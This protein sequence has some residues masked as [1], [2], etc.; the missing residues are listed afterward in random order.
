MRR[1][2]KE[3]KMTQS[4]LAEG[5]I[6]VPYLSLIENERANPPADVIS[7]LA[8]RLK[9]SLHE[10]QGISDPLVLKEAH[11]LIEKIR[12]SMFNEE[13]ENCRHYL[14]KLEEFSPLI[15]DEKLLMKIDLIR[16]NV[17]DQQLQAERAKQLL[18]SFE[19]KWV[20]FQSCPDTFVSY[21]RMKGNIE[22][23]Q[24]N[25]MK[26]IQHYQTALPLFAE[27]KDELEKGY[28]YTNL[29][30]SY[31]L[32]TKPQMGV[33]Y[34]EKAIAILSQMDRWQELIAVYH[35]M[36]CC[37]VHMGEHDEAQQYFER[38]LKMSQQMS[39]IS[40]L[41]TARAYHEMGTTKHQL[42]YYDEAL[43]Y[44]AL[45]LKTA[46]SEDDDPLPYWEVGKIFESMTKTYLKKGQ[47]EQA[48]R[49]LNKALQLL[50]NHHI[51]LAESWIQLGHLH[52]AKGE[53]SS[54]EQVYMN[55]ITVFIE[56]E[57]Y[58]KVARA[59]HA[60]GLYFHNQGD[61]GK[62]SHWSRLACEYYAKLVPVGEF[63]HILPTQI[64]NNNPT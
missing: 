46:K 10:L 2:R 38:M 58:S 19:Q 60:L 9:M 40:P 27:M 17:M 49:Y 42:D 47:L 5:I 4:E 59:A 64:E 1:R 20:N 11:L 26:A 44:F 51:S 13:H 61:E 7:P 57:N 23:C 32:L 25:Y 48:E 31:L 56:H 14:Q 12:F 50:D 52:Y 53:F 24:G 22:I 55:A 62:S 41:F 33:I 16:I 6:S 15:R 43:Q 45:A 39:G 21:L 36:G 28:L 34:S 8:Q 63:D 18:H 37:Y 3:L 29:A 35:I 30:C 54:F